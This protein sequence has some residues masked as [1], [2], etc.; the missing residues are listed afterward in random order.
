MNAQRNGKG[1][2]QKRKATGAGAPTIHDGDKYFDAEFTEDELQALEERILVECGFQ[3]DEDDRRGHSWLYT[4][5]ITL[6]WELGRKLGLNTMV[7]HEWV[8][9]HM[10]RELEI[11]YKSFA[12]NVPKLSIEPFYMAIKSR[13]PY[14]KETNNEM[15]LKAQKHHMHLAFIDWIDAECE[16]IACPKSYHGLGCGERYEDPDY[17]T[18]VRRVWKHNAARPK[19]TLVHSVGA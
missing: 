10:C 9:I 16:R 12:K 3:D 18:A 5:W 17:M 11:D 15:R 13:F 8:T 2:S 7:S 1:R 14:F 6:G 19:L 4:Q